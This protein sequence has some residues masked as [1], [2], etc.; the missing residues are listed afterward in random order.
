MNGLS[1]AVV[2]ILQEL[3][4]LK[5]LRERIIGKKNFLCHS[6]SLLER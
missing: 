3:S 5:V 4:G 2:N 1:L 6:F